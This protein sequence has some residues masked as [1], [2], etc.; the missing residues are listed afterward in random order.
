MLKLK[1]T[2]WASIA[3]II[4]AVAVVGSLF[5]VGYQIKQNTEVSL[6][7]NR[8]SIAT[9]AQELALYSAEVGIYKLL[10]AADTD[11]NKLSNVEQDRLVAYIGA[12]LR[13]TEEAF[14]LYRDGML[15]EEYWSTRANVLL[16]MLKSKRTRTIYHQT[17]KGGFYTKAFSV[18]VDKTLNEKYEIQ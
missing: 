17:K 6:A 13:T 9:R 16:T 2:E 11:S 7:A 15:N 8:Q 4:S 5:Y 18:W 14:L 1:L 12:L 3:E 10:F